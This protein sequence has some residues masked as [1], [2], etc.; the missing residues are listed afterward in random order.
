MIWSEVFAS[1]RLGGWYVIILFYPWVL[2][3]ALKIQDVIL[4]TMKQFSIIRFA[5]DDSMFYFKN[6]ST[7]IFAGTHPFQAGCLQ[8]TLLSVLSIC[9]RFR[10][11]F[12]RLNVYLIFINFILQWGIG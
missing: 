4:P 11:N 12:T 8:A 9:A 5:V 2:C 6:S 1:I 7:P 3:L 10:P